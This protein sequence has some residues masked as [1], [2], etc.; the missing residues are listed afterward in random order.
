MTAYATQDDLWKFYF[1]GQ[2]PL[3]NTQLVSFTFRGLGW[4]GLDYESARAQ[5]VY[6]QIAI[7]Y[8]ITGEKYFYTLPDLGPNV[9]IALEDLYKAP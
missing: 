5:S 6:D 4:G 1:N 9:P 7:Q 3:G 2:P 8:T